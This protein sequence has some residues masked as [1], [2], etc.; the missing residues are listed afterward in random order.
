MKHHDLI[1][2]EQKALSLQRSGKI[3]EAAHAFAMLVKEQS[4]WEHGTGFY[5]LACCQEKLGQLDFAENSYL[6]ALRLWP[7]NP[8]FLGGYAAFQASH[9]DPQSA[10]DTYLKLLEVERKNRSPHGVFAESAMTALKTLGK[11]MG[12][13][14]EDIA[15]KIDPVT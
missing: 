4:D 9:R 8:Y 13:S 12:L 14:D 1:E 6:E 2:L 15:K 11:K 3:R 10:F 5:S 7:N